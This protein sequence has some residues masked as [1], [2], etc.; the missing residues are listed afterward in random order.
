MEFARF[1]SGY[2][3]QLFFFHSIFASF[4]CTDILFH[5]MHCK[6]WT[7]EWHI[8]SQYG[9]ILTTVFRLSFFSIIIVA[10]VVVVVAYLLNAH[11]MVRSFV[12]LSSLLRFNRMISMDVCMLKSMISYG[13][14]LDKP[15]VS[16]SNT[17]RR[18]NLIRFMGI[19]TITVIIIIIIT[20]LT[21]TATVSSRTTKHVD[22]LAC[23][24]FSRISLMCIVICAQ[25]TM[26]IIITAAA[27]AAATVTFTLTNAYP[28]SYDTLVAQCNTFA[29]LFHTSA[30]NSTHAHILSCASSLQMSICV[31][32]SFFF[33]FMFSFILKIRLTRKIIII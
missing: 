2:S 22:R 7:N 3:S 33:F 28:R 25:I 15:E 32:V 27:A 24:S 13:V 14:V 26:S 1:F 19:I 29:A 10:V 4:M 20:A 5:D 23:T 16:T 17:F 21:S 9:A 8:L 30:Q 12:L 31:C 11:S 18:H 6:L